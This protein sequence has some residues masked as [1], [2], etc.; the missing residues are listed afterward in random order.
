MNNWTLLNAN[1]Y[2]LWIADCVTNIN[3]LLTD[4]PL[5]LSVVYGSH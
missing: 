5:P 3:V 1:S 4:I 2:E